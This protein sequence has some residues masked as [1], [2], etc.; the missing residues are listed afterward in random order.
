MT[1]DTSGIRAEVARRVRRTSVTAVARA[2]GMPREAVARLAGGLPVRA[3]TL[4][5][6]RDRLAMEGTNAI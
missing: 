3:G 2:L 4:A 5:L 1:H 6:A